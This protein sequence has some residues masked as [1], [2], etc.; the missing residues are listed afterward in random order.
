M[1]AIQFVTE[2]TDRRQE[3]F[4]IAHQLGIKVINAH[5]VPNP[6]KLIAIHLL[7]PDLDALEDALQVAE[8]DMFPAIVLHSNQ[9]WCK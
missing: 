8:R 5:N 1:N 9:T 7:N 6:R 4:D 2:I 3:L